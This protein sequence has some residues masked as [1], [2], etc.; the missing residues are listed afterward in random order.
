[1]PRLKCRRVGL[2][3]V[4]LAEDGSGLLAPIP[5]AKSEPA[6]TLEQSFLTWILSG[7][8]SRTRVC[9][10]VSPIGRQKHDAYK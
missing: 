10:K 7:H 8:D 1:M 6:F 5:H 3:A 2:S 4:V 9:S